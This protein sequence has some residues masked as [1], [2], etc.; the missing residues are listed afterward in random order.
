MRILDHLGRGKAWETALAFSRELQHEYETNAFN[1][2]RLAELLNLQAELY[3]SIAHSDRQFGYVYFFSSFHR[4]AN[5]QHPCSNYYRVAFY[6]Q[7]P[8]SVSNKQFV[9]RG[10]PL[11]TLGGFIDRM[12]S[13]H[14]K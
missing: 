2:A 3:A 11:E 10:Q 14:P 1:Y 4:P 8:A 7:W 6:G 12:L 13:K 9:Y 5:A